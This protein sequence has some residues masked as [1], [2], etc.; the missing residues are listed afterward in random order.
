VC[1]CLYVHSQ[2]LHWLC[3]V[4]IRR[5]HV[6]SP[7]VQSLNSIPSMLI[8]VWPILCQDATTRSCNRRDGLQEW[9][10]GWLVLFM[11]AHMRYVLLT[12]TFKLLNPRPRV[13]HS[14]DSRSFVEL[15]SPLYER[16]AI[17]ERQ[18]EAFQQLRWPA[19]SCW[20]SPVQYCA[21]ILNYK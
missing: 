4:F 5:S 12:A 13:C 2:L 6:L 9:P 15:S 20:A 3:S 19:A 21:R 14:S 7:K 17:H 8:H 11:H 10:S 16:Q 1:V 18:A